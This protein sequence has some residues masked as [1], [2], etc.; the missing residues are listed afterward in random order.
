MRKKTD[1]RSRLMKY[2]LCNC[3]CSLEF[4]APTDIDIVPFDLHFIA[5]HAIATTIGRV[6]IANVKGEVMPRAEDYT[7]LAPS[8]RKGA[9][10]MRAHIVDSVKE[11]VDVK[12]C[13]GLLVDVYNLD[14]ARRY[15]IYPGNAYKTIRRH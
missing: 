3:E 6:A 4:P 8:L 13:N 11:P 9:T 15:V 12:H 14:L 1:W 2:N 7:S 10:L 5:T